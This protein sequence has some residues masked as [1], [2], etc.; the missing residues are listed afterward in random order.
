LIIPTNES[1]VLKRGKVHSYI[2]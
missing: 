1:F 2:N